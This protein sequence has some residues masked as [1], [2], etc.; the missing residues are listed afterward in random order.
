MIYLFIVVQLFFLFKY[1]SYYN[2]PV[3]YYV[4]S[5][6]CF[7]YWG[8]NK[9]EVSSGVNSSRLYRIFGYTWHRYIFLPFLYESKFCIASS[10]SMSLTTQLLKLRLYFYFISKNIMDLFGNMRLFVC[11]MRLFV[12]LLEKNILWALASCGNLKL[13]DLF[14]I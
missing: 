14:P 1:P 11:N 7:C 3:L 8:L 10:L 5:W 4:C 6:W 9:C 2:G 12:C 13:S